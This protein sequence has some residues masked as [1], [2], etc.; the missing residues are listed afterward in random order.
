MAREMVLHCSSGH[1][2]RKKAAVV[3]G[4]EWNGNGVVG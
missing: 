3:C 1:K 2:S 4:A